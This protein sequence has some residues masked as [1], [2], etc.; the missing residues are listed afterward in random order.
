MDD[1]LYT[2]P[3]NIRDLLKE[4]IGRLVSGKE[5]IPAL[6]KEKNVVSI[7]DQ[8]TYSILSNNY[9]PIFCIVDYYVKRKKFS[10]DSIK[11]IKS[12]GDEVIKVSNPK[13]TITNALWIAIENAFKLFPKKTIRIEV[14]GEE[15]LASLAAI[16]LAPID[17]TI[18]YGLPNKGVLIVKPTEEIKK[19]VKTVLN[20]M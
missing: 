1:I 3:N 16:Y 5:L 17:V 8:V 10:E 19:K 2:L 6:L 12:Y 15:D 20:M 7:G 18:I 9:Q 11:F 4:P 13:G 14:D